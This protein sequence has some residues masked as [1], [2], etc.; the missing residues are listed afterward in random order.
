MRA[1]CCCCFGQAP[2]LFAQAFF[3]RTDI[4]R[5][6]RLLLREQFRRLRVHLLAFVL[7]SLDLQPRILDLRF[8]LFLAVEK[9]RTFARAVARPP[10]PIRGCVVPATAV[11]GGTRR[12]FVPRSREP[13]CF[14]SSRALA[15]SRCWRRFSRAAVSSTPPASCGSRSRVFQLAACVGQSRALSADL[16]VPAPRGSGFRK[17]PCRFSGAAG[18]ANFPAH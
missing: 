7:Q 12:T 6:L 11:A 9:R 5:F 14:R 16:P 1:R 18:G 4:S 13:L 2:A 3:A 8:R 15:V 10:A 17:P